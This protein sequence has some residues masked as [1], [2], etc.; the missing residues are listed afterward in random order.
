[1]TLEHCRKDAK[2]LLR[3]VRA[4]EPDALARAQ[5]VTA[6]RNRFQLSDA[7]H[8]VA[9]E[10]GYRT[11]PELKRALAEAQVDRTERMLDSGLE[12]V[13]GDPV[14]VKVV[15]RGRR[16]LVTDEGGAVARA[17]Q[18]PGWRYAAERAMA[19]DALNLSRGGAV[20]VPAVEGGAPIDSLVERVA[21]LSLAVYQEILDLD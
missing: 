18:P 2:A 20:F 4:G 11:W 16:Y 7:Q 19:E 8:V 1:M 21:T 12:Y 5:R 9:V 13:P 14:L 3:G 17:G 15:Q 6:Y 10:R